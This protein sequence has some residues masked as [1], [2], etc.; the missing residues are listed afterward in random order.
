MVMICCFHVTYDKEGALSS[1]WMQIV[2][3]VNSL[4]LPFKVSIEVERQWVHFVTP[5]GINGN[6]LRDMNRII[7]GIESLTAKD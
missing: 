1:R 5:H 6:E 7:R 4:K 2:N 3:R